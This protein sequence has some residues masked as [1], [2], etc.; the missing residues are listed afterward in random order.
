MGAPMVRADSYGGKQI[1]YWHGN[2]AG[3]AK[4]WK[5]TDHRRF[6]GMRISVAQYLTPLFKTG[7]RNRFI[8]VNESL[9]AR[10]VDVENKTGDLPLICELVIPPSCWRQN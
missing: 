8:L 2:C 9:F 10:C 4:A 1:K 5:L 6:N 7:S 3:L